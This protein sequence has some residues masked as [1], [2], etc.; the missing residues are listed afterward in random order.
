MFGYY[1]TLVYLVYTLLIKNQNIDINI[2]SI[3]FFNFN[4]HNKCH[5]AS[6]KHPPL[7]NGRLV[8]WKLLD[9]TVFI[10]I[11]FAVVRLTTYNEEL[12]EVLN[13]FHRQRSNWQSINVGSTIWTGDAKRQVRVILICLKLI[14]RAVIDLSECMGVLCTRCCKQIK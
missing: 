11:V 9:F 7:L 14:T 1:N 2:V 4:I 8:K 6:H 13:S 3:F 12:N 5:L 10:T